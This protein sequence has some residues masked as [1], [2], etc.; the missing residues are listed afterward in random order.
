MNLLGRRTKTGL[1][2]LWALFLF[3]CEDPNEIGLELRAD[4]DKVGVSYTEIEIPS[5]VISLDSILTSS[6]ARLLAGNYFHPDLGQITASGY[7]RFSFGT[8]ILNI[9]DSAVYDSIY[10]NLNVDYTYGSGISEIQTFSV[11]ELTEEINDTVAYFSFS[12]IAYEPEPIGT[13]S[14]LLPAEEDTVLQFRLS[15]DYGN[16]LFNASVDTTIIDPDDVSTLHALFKGLALVADPANNS[17]LRYDQESDDSE[18]LLYYHFP[19]DTAFRAYQFKFFT[20]VN[21]NRLIPDRTGTPLEGVEDEPYTEFIPSDAKTYLQAGTGLIPKLDMSPVLEFFDSIPNVA[22]NQ[23]ILEIK[24]NDLGLN[25][26]PPSFL[27]LYFTDENNRRI[28]SGPEFLGIT[29]EGRTELIR[30]PYNDELS[31]YETPTTLYTGNI[32]QRLLPYN[33]ILLYP[34]EFGLGLTI[35]HFQIDPG[36]IRAKIYYTKLK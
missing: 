25:E 17:L 23:V 11:H 5:S 32:L 29:I 2:V 35:N 3:Q 16:A 18:L 22:F 15:D 28:R 21:F 8:S 34:P 1:V 13:G 30:P 12:E 14:F 31:N 9:P 20:T 6:S 33:Q 27:T 4:S 26:F 10:L 36:S 7:T 24:I 19:D